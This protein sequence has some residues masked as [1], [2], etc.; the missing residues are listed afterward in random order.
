M[1]AG[2]IEQV[3]APEEVYHRPANA[4]VYNFLGN[5]NL[6]HGR[7][8]NGRIY[9]GDTMLEL[10]AAGRR[11]ANG[12]SGKAALYMRPHLLE[13]DRA[14]RGLGSFRA[15]V[16]GINAA[17]PQVKVELLA[18][19]GDALQAEIDH[20]RYRSLAIEPGARVFVHPKESRVFV[21]QI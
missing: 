11:S 20:E 16:Q 7:I 19:W 5:V 15:T 1:N 21:Y 2:R 13:L 14:P 6:F 17:G 8:E 3:G 4:F 9:L 12:T 18:D 10:D